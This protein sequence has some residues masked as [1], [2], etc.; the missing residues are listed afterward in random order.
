MRWVNGSFAA[1]HSGRNTTNSVAKRSTA[2]N[3]EK[4]IDI[5][6]KNARKDAKYAKGIKYA[7]LYFQNLILQVHYK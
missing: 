5:Y 3:L 1:P 6:R 4:G 7:L 2:K